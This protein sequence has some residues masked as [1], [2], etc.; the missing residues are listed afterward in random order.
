MAVTIYGNGQ[1]FNQVLQVVKT[2]IF[3]TTST[4]WVDITGMTVNITP[5]SANSKI[6][7]MGDLKI[8]GTSNCSV[9]IALVRNG[10]Q[11]YIG[12]TRGSRQR[13]TYATSNDTNL[14]DVY[15][16]CNV[17]L[18]SP[19]TTSAVT[20]KFQMRTE[21]GNTGT[22][23]LNTDGENPD[24]QEGSTSASSITVMEV[25]YS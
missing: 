16:S 6:L 23:Y 24:T 25:A 12:D 10:T 17:Y 9:N 3:S 20:Y 21:A 2:D 18:D 14:N 11:I 13:V 8:G 19:A 15:A 4:S 5:K 22:G 7:I 1:L